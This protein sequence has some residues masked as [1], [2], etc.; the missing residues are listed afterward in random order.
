[1][2]LSSQLA[3]QELI[4][5][6]KVRLSLAEW[7]RHKGFEPAE[8]HLLIIN[9]IEAFLSSD[10]KCFCCLHLQV[11]PRAPTSRSC[12]LRGIWRATQSTA[13]WLLLTLSSSP[14]AGEDAS[15]MTS[16]ATRTS[17]ASLCQRYVPL[18]DLECETLWP[19]SGPILQLGMRC[20]RQK[21]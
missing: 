8:H 17:L 13:S 7:A 21:P 3:A 2:E 1:M 10:T 9:E 15:A 19:W 4:K 16:Q 14:N 20:A 18:A 5:R 12:C 6:R 11:R